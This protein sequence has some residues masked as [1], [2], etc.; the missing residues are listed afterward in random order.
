M[1]RYI[2]VDYERSNFSVY[3]SV[4]PDDGASK[5]VPIYPVETHQHRSTLSRGGI[6]GIIISAIM[7]VVLLAGACFGHR[8]YKVR[9]LKVLKD[10]KKNAESEEVRGNQLPEEVVGEISGQSWHPEMDT[11]MV[12]EIDDNELMAELPEHVIFELCGS[13]FQPEQDVSLDKNR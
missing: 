3:Q 6:I 1:L 7:L 13:G 11:G 10:I 5:I 12:P 9:K 2:I 4:F 8:R